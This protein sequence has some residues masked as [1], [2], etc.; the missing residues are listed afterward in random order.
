MP[1]SR[2][3]PDARGR[4]VPIY[5]LQN[6]WQSP[7]LPEPVFNSLRARF[8][9]AGFLGLGL[10]AWMFW[11]LII[12]HLALVAAIITATPVL[13]TI[14][15]LALITTYIA[16]WLTHKN[17][18]PTPDPV[19]LAGALLEHRRC[20]SCVYSLSDAP[21]GHDGLATCPECGAAW[22]LPPAG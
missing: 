14:A 20:P 8:I 5:S 12:L 6:H 4:Q 16:Y 19:A 7:D 13:I 11:L 15:C 3:I 18:L 22:A 21:R 17:Q 2:T 10:P 1:L 9:N